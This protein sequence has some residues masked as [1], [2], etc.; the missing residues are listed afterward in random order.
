M[1]I[2]G[3]LVNKKSGKIIAVGE[4]EALHDFISQMQQLNPKHLKKRDY[5]IDIQS[6]SEE[7]IN[8]T[9]VCMY[10]SFGNRLNI[11]G[12]GEV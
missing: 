5:Y 10:M 1:V 3:A 9:G 6:P 11:K 12:I 7:I 8:Q 4:W 2:T